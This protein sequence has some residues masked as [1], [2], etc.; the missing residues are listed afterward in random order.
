MEK[1]V[2]TEDDFDNAYNKVKD[3]LS[4]TVKGACNPESLKTILR[5]VL[6]NKYDVSITNYKTMLAKL[7]A[8]SDPVYRSCVLA[9]VHP[10]IDPHPDETIKKIIEDLYNPVFSYRQM[11]IEYDT[12][13]G[14]A[15]C[16]VGFVALQMKKLDQRR[17]ESAA[18]SRKS[19]KAIIEIYE[20][21]LITGEMLKWYFDEESNI[22]NLRDEKKPGI[23]ILSLSPT[24]YSEMLFFDYEADT[25]AGAVERYA[26]ALRDDTAVHA[27]HAAPGDGAPS[28][29]SYS[30][31]PPPIGRGGSRRR[32]RTAHR[33]RKSHRKSKRVHHTRRKHTRRHRHSRHRHSR[34]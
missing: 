22:Y 7:K 5:D 11:R 8:G 23:T 14:L 27:V 32:R 1:Q 25:A 17:K 24:Q 29:G 16:P 13:T 31:P 34:R 9:I 4:E 18:L 3:Q 12:D 2:Y 26:A 28:D 21:H 15:R 33:K 19:K 10:Y 30:V 20:H 6:A